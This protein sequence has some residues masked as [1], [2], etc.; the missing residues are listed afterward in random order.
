MT[1]FTCDFTSVTISTESTAPRGS[2][3]AEAFDKILQEIE[4][5]GTIAEVWPVSPLR[6]AVECPRCKGLGVLYVA[7]AQRPSS[8]PPTR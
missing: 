3:V 2:V 5:R 7:N 4:E 1:K 8:D 6:R